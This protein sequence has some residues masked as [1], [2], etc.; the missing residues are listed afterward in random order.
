MTDIL[1][2]QVKRKL[3]I[4]W[5]DEDTSL[6]LKDIIKSAEVVLSYKLGITDVDFDYS[7][8]GPENI[9]FLAYCLYEWN[10]IPNEFDANYSNLIIQT[11][12]K[13]EVAQYR[14]S[15]QEGDSNE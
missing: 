4:T 13:H 7:V 10:H 2:N 9:L 1:L 11:R 3:N 6:R 12:I 15:L 14:E 5:D 8:K